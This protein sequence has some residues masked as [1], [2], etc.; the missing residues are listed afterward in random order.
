MLYSTSVLSV[1]MIPNV[2]FRIIRE[3]NDTQSAIILAPSLKCC[4]IC[5]P[6]RYYRVSKMGRITRLR[7]GNILSLFTR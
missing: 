4:T 2:S 5:V 6:K 7:L 3:D 1:R